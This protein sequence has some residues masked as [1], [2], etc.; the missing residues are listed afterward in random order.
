M[1]WMAITL[2]HY[3]TVRHNS[4][5]HISL[6]PIAKSLRSGAKLGIVHDLIDVMTY[7]KQPFLLPQL[8]LVKELTIHTYQ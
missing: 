6:H 7:I 1:S 8:T 2:S 3:S 4:P 5:Q